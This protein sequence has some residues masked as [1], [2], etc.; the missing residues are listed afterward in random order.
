[1]YDVVCAHN[2]IKN[3]IYFLWK[4][5]SPGKF[6][7]LIRSLNLVNLISELLRQ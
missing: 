1:M 2:N 6:I 3:L 5:D 7:Y 4:N